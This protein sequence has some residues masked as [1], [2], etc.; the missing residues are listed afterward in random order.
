MCFS[1]SLVYKIFEKK[2]RDSSTLVPTKTNLSNLP[3]LHYKQIDSPIMHV[4]EI[5]K[6]VGEQGH[7]QSLVETFI[8]QATY[9]CGTHQPQLQTWTTTST[10]F[11]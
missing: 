4:N 8:G 11:I 7:L 6:N 10:Y 9:W 2:V 1:F 3:S 5:S